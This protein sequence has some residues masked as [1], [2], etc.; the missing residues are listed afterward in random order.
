MW[1]ADLN[2]CLRSIAMTLFN[3]HVFYMWVHALG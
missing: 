1:R 2:G 3:K